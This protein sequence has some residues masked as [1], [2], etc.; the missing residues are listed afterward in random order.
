VPG[1]GTSK[2]FEQLYRENVDRVYALCLRMSW[3]ALGQELAG[4]VRA[5][6][7]NLGSF[8]GDSA[9]STWIHRVTVNV[10]IESKRS[11]ARRSSHEMAVE[12][13]GDYE[14]PSTPRSHELSIDLERAIADL[15]PG[16]RRVFV[17][18]DMEGYKHEEIAGMTGTAVGT[19]KAQLFRARRLLREALKK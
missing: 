13:L 10:V 11:A 1:Q 9:F 17:L 15:P 8:R 14:R 4:G 18:Y 16:A 12:D 3:T 2:P 19:V 6:G 5:G 7:K